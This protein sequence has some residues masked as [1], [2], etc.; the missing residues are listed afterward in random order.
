MNIANACNYNNITTSENKTFQDC[1]TAAKTFRTDFA[2]CFAK[3]KSQAEACECV[4]PI[5][6]D[7][8][9]LLNSCNSTIKDKR[10]EIRDAKNACVA[11]KT[12]YLLGKI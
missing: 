5:D 4:D 7:N 6:N 12:T 2:T 11:G 10:D 3:S 8:L 1:L 9:S